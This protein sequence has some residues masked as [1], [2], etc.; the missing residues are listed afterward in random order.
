[1][2][3][4]FEIISFNNQV[5]ANK[6]FKGASNNNEIIAAKTMHL[7]LCQRTRDRRDK[8]VGK[9]EIRGKIMILLK[10][11]SHTKTRG[12]GIRLKLIAFPDDKPLTSELNGSL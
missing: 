4:F 10:C 11:C 1:M 6:K 8:N 7:Y 3:L 9:K 12:I 2:S 5:G